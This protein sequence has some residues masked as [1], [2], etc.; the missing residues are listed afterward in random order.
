MATISRRPR[1]MGD[2]R[3]VLL[4]GLVAGGEPRT[5]VLPSE[6]VAPENLGPSPQRR[7]TRLVPGAATRLPETDAVGGIN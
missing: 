2:V 3:A 7:P 6:F 1:E 5:V 4:L